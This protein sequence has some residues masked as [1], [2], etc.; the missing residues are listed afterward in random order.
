MLGLAFAAAH[1]VEAGPIVLV[2]CGTF[3]PVA[4]QVRYWM[5]GFVETLSD[6]E[7]QY[8]ALYRD[9]AERRYT[10]DPTRRLA[11]ELMVRMRTDATLVLMGAPAEAR[12]TG[13][14]IY[15]NT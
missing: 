10:T 9:L 2:G 15:E 5:E 1:P 13:T 4:R 3:D 12:L 14:R 11:E 8:R 7:S 6:E